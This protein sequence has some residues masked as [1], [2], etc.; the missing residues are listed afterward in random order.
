MKEKFINACKRLKILWDTYKIVKV[1][2]VS[3]GLVGMGVGGYVATDDPEPIPE[4]VVVDAVDDLPVIDYALKEHVYPLIPHSQPVDP[5]IVCEPMI[6]RAVEA[7][8][9]THD[10]HGLG[11]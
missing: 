3:L 10:P 4:P 1:I 6:N 8:A 11:H 7:F 9:R 2:A 5:V